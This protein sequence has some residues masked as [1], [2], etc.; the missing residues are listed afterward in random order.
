MSNVSQRTI[1]LLH[2]FKICVTADVVEACQ[3]ATLVEP[4]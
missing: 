2:A 4:E 3:L 1:L